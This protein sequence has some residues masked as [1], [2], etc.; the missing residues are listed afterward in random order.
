[1]PCSLPYALL[2]C[3]AL[4]HCTVTA[5]HWTLTV[6]A[7]HCTLTVTALHCNVTA[8]DYTVTALYC[9]VTAFQT[10]S[11]NIDRIRHS[12]LCSHCTALYWTLLFHCNPYCDICSVHQPLP[13][14]YRGQCS[15]VSPSLQSVLVYIQTKQCTLHSAV[16]LGTSK[17]SSPPLFH[18]LWQF[19][20]WLL[21]S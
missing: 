6:T 10:L 12:T 18:S 3:S 4:L 9:T 2:R 16:H 15:A 19:T 20:S 17:N 1:M 14:N 11:H 21:V 13:G 8:L 5:L 7:L